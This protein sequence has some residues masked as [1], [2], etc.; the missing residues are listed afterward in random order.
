MEK[1]KIY[2]LPYAGGSKSIYSGWI[3]KYKDIAKIV[4]VEYSGHGSRFGEELYISADDV[5]KYIISEKPENYA[6]YGH[7]M[8]ALVSLLT[9]IRLESEYSYAPK[10]VIIGGTRPPHLAYK[11]EPIADLPK[12]EF[13]QRI[14]D[15]GQMDPEIKAEPE[16]IDILYEILH[17][18]AVLGE[19]YTDFSE[20]PKLKTD[21]FVMTGLQ[22]DE[23]AEEDMKEWRNYSSGSFEL[24]TFDSGHFFPFRCPEFHKYIESVIGRVRWNA[25]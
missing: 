9:A 6:V 3:D 16:L 4:P 19:S 21:M 1:I 12:D 13:M 24:K 10:A 7:S 17:A 25:L 20:L 8:G 15:M 18:D 14:F 2:C 5:Y 11:D 22:D 23:V